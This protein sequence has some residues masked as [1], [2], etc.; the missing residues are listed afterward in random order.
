[1]RRTKKKRPSFDGEA[2]RIAGVWNQSCLPYQADRRVT[3][4]QARR[5]KISAF[6]YPTITQISALT[7][8]Q[9]QV[10]AMNYNFHV[11]LC[12]AVVLASRV[13]KGRRLLLFGLF[14]NS[15]EKENASGDSMTTKLER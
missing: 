15:P 6:G 11:R 1:M 14:R 8:G 5:V 13:R 3:V 9:F 10:M 2:F 12:C 4:S 7:A